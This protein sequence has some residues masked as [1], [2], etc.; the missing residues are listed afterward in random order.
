MKKSE[1]SLRFKE[2]Y[3]EHFE[4]GMSVKN[5]AE[6]YS[7]SV[8]HAYSLIR[9]LA[10]EI[11]VPYESLIPHPHTEHVVGDRKELK[12]VDP[13][14]LSNFQNEF[15]ATMSSIDKSLNVL[16]EM[17]KSWMDDIGL[18]DEEEE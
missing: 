7:L 14:N 8:P 6:L 18:Q 9:E 11:G 4:A 3:L 2:H 1:R 16:N 13:I 17:L 15:R 5:S 12:R 10:D